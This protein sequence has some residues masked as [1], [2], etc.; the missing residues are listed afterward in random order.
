ME[1]Y[2]IIL[3]RN[4]HKKKILKRFITRE[5]AASFFKNLV[6]KSEDV[7]F[8][9]KFENGKQVNYEIGIVEKSSGSHVPTY[10]TD[11]LGRNIKVVLD[12]DN[13]VLSEIKQYRKEEK[14]FDIK[15][16][17]KITVSD[18][19][20]K[21]LKSDTLKVISILNNKIVVQKDEVFNVF[22]LKSEEECLRFIETISMFFFK[23][24]RSDCLF[25]ND[26]ST[27]QRKYL[28]DLLEKNGFDKK[29]LYRK[30]T[31]HPQRA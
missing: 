10:L 21:Y 3:F 14:I 1:N 19:I 5:K 30:Y 11:N 9:V 6:K 22:S 23:N 28:I 2:T 7:I 13:I 31:T 27:P 29:I 24:K 25:V 4:K 17:K 20:K 8:D 12:E 16:N 26:T 15:E 18:F